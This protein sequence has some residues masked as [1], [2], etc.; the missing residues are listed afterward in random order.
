MI[1][2]RARYTQVRQKG[3]SVFEVL[4]A[5]LLVSVGLAG[6][7]K[8]QAYLNIQ[9]E[10]A[11]VTLSAVSQAES[12]LEVFRS[13]PEQLPVVQQE[14]L[15]LHQTPVFLELRFYPDVPVTGVRR[16]VVSVR[17]QDRWLNAHL[18]EMETNIDSPQ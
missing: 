9:A 12:V 16:V 11:L 13:Q 15:H 6:M 18:V 1:F 8:L 5:L 3:F 2:K 14:A 7:M 4:V 17:W 10:N